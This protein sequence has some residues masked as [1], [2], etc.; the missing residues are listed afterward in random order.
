MWVTLVVAIL[1][2]AYDEGKVEAM[3]DKLN[4]LPGDL[5]TVFETLLH[6]DNPDKHETICLLQWVLF[7]RRALKPEELYFSMRA[8]THPG[9]LGAW[10]RSKITSED[11]QH[12]ITSS[13]RGLIET[14]KGEDRTVQF[15]HESVN[16]FLLRNKRLQTL[17]SALQSSPMGMSHDC[18]RACC[19]SYLNTDGLE[20]SGRS[21]LVEE[22]ALS[23]PL[24]DYASIHVLHH[25]EE[26]QRKGIVQTELLHW[27]QNCETF[28][29]LRNFHN[30]FEKIP[31]LGCSKDVGP[32]YILSL[33]GCQELLRAVLYEGGVDVNA[34]G[35][36]YDSAL[37]AAAVKGE[38]EI[39]KILL[40][41]E[42]DANAQGG[43][44]GSTLQAAVRQGKKE[45]VKMLLAQGADANA[46]GGPHG[47]ALQA[48]VTKLENTVV[49]LLLE[50]GADVNAQY[51][52]AAAHQIGVS[53][54]LTTVAVG[55]SLIMCTSATSSTMF[56]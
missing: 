6:E 27:V 7:A 28:E 34:R 18:L 42:A 4:K 39:V 29:R 50:N 37:Q 55:V 8:G 2:R 49:G 38:E 26:A 56:R 33:H 3:H 20:V 41:H 15:I 17:D 32:L 43:V 11:I 24:L 36:A 53:A 30:V 14:R 31:G 44:Y 16:D 47:S 46:Q 25:A 54:S 48:A 1:N 19:M 51:E 52:P 23:Y 21:L 13:S 9:N 12:R 5:E 40:V 22:T 35:G 45:I 10:D